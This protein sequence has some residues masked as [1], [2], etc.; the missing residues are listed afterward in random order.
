MKHKNL[1]SVIARLTLTVLILT[2]TA[3]SFAGCEGLPPEVQELLG[4]VMNPPACDHVFTDGV[5]EKCGDPECSHL[6]IERCICQDC[7]ETIH[8]E[9]VYNPRREPLCDEIGHIEVYSCYGCEKLFS[10]AEGRAE[11]INQ[12]SIYISALG[13]SHEFDSDGIC[14]RCGK[15]SHISVDNCACIRCEAPVH[16]NL[17]FIEYVRQT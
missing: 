3:F 15:C 2:V 9:M 7:N 5:C 8:T 1:F 6:N 14:G 10:D 12:N 4:G 13:G 17:A 11:I 16:S